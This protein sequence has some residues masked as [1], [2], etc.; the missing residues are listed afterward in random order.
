MV[1]QILVLV[2]F[3]DH[4]RA[5]RHNAQDPTKLKHVST[6]FTGYPLPRV[7]VLT[8]ERNASF[9]R[10]HS[11]SEKWPKRVPTQEDKS[12]SSP[13]PAAVTILFWAE[14]RFA[15]QR[16]KRR[17]SRSVPQFGHAGS[18]QT[19][20]PIPGASALNCGAINRLG[21]LR[22]LPMELL[23]AAQLYPRTLP[24]RSPSLP[25]KPDRLQST[26]TE[27]ADKAFVLAPRAL[28]VLSLLTG[29]KTELCQDY[30]RTC[31]QAAWDKIPITDLSLHVQ[32]CTMQATGKVMDTLVSRTMH[33]GSTW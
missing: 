11:N 29:Y 27:R 5:G 21:L 15:S 10:S 22:L 2:H 4:S 23:V 20:R 17:A 24:S 8:L 16:R 18:V 28:N 6:S 1:L 26:L 30:S 9:C 13:K 19:W 14:T 32:R 31:E 25:S 3:L 12:M 33:V 7:Q